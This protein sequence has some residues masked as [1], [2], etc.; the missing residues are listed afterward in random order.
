MT[1]TMTDHELRLAAGMA[2]LEVALTLYLPLG[3]AVT[4]CCDPD[5]VGVGRQHAK[6][7]DSPGKAPMHPWKALQ[8]RLPSATEV[9][10]LWRSFPYGN[11]GCVLGEISGL[12]R[13]DIDGREGEALLTQWSAGDLPLTWTFRS[14]PQGRGLLYAWPH[15][16][17]CKS[18][19][20]ASPGDHT[21]LR[22]MGNGSQTVLPPSRHPSGS[23]YTWDIGHSPHDLQVAPAPAWLIERLRITP[24]QEYSNPPVGTSETPELA[25]VASA[26]AAIPNNHADY[27]TWL[28]IGMALH[29]TGA[30]WA[31]A[32][33]DD[34][35]H[36]SDKFNPDKQAKSWAS[37]GSSGKQRLVHIGTL[38]HRAKAYG[39]VPPSTS[40]CPSA[41]AQPDTRPAIVHHVVPDYILKHPD[42]R[43][44]EHWKRIYRRT[45]IL[46][47]RYAREGGL[48][49]QK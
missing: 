22:L 48:L 11:V 44:R 47:E 15:D 42:P 26:L 25:R 40:E 20:Q 10:A 27:D 17:P 2:C 1:S 35:S 43:V 6:R 7:C 37:F 33:W 3:L 4:C 24:Q 18:T 29:A 13:V 46:K 31:R 14:S 28:M 8:T 5:H 30:E 32:L 41:I 36:Q 45:A 21:E 34:W 19:A 16:L 9:Q 12:V 38:Y 49:C 23:L 39:W